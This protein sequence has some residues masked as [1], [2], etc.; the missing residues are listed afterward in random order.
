MCARRV[1]CGLWPGEKRRGSAGA[2]L[3]QSATELHGRLFPAS[4][5][6][7]PVGIVAMKDD[8]PL[9]VEAEGNAVGEGHGV[10]SA[11]IAQRIFG[12]EL[13]VSGRDSGRWHRPESRPE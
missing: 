13:E 10:Q 5:G 8:V 11:K 7:S 9:A 1:R 3:V 12:F 2:E 6:Q 4:I